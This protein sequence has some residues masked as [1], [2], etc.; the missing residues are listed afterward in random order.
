MVGE[1]EEMHDFRSC[2]SIST[3]D[4]LEWGIEGKLADL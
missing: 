4:T 1:G 2:S 3:L